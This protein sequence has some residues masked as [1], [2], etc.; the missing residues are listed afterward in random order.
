MKSSSRLHQLQSHFY[1][2]WHLQVMYSREGEDCSAVRLDEAKHKPTN[3]LTTTAG[4]RLPLP[5]E[6]LSRRMKQDA[7]H[8][9]FRLKLLLVPLD[10]R[11]QQHSRVQN[12]SS[13]VIKC[14]CDTETLISL[15]VC[16]TKE[17]K[18]INQETEQLWR[19]LLRNPVPWELRETRE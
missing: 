11:T 19:W 16:R 1:L 13:K 17:W 4:S 8:W 5:G 2:E 9:H 15:K 3:Q 10:S 18:G 7:K 14:V 6:K 12:Q